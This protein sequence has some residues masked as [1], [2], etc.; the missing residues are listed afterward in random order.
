[1]NK[2]VEYSLLK[3]IVL[4]GLLCCAKL[5]INWTYFVQKN[6]ETGLKGNL[7]GKLRIFK[8]FY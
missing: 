1:M 6:L 4:A 8:S 2:I 5:H 3:M 7:D